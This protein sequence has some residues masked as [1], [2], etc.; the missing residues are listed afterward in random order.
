MKIPSNIICPTFHGVGQMLTTTPP[1]VSSDSK[2][3][4]DNLWT[5][6]YDCIANLRDGGV[7][8]EPGGVAAGAGALVGAR[9]AALVRDLGA[10]LY[11]D[12]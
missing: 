11:H 7:V 9:G 4:I 3:C 10:H 12:T 6:P 8:G 2:M 1:R 5:A